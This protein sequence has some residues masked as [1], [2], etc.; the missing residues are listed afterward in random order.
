MISFINSW[1]Q[2]IIL[3]VIIATIIEIILPEGNNKKY[4]KTI[5]GIYIMFVVMYPL[6]SRISNKNISIKNIIGNTTSKMKE[7]ETNNNITI[8]TND[9]IEKTYKQKLE[10]DLNN[11]LGEK[12]YAIN[13]LDIDVEI[14][15][16]ETYGQINSIFMQISKT[17]K[18]EGNK[19]NK[20]NASNNSVNQIEKVEVNISNSNTNKRYDMNQ[21]NISKEDIDNL[22]YYLNTT[23]MI[24]KEKIHI[25]E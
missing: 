25:N 23:Y 21:E 8:E 24:E 3:A 4:V 12:G 18:L 7:F 20:K 1:A 11:R 16:E 13:S 5:I 14:E 17:Q 9:Y 6:I 2:G 10:E 22:K 19:V 15:N